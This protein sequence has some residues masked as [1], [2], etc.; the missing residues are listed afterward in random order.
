MVVIV[1]QN[2]HKEKLVRTQP[3]VLLPAVCVPQT[4]LSQLFVTSFPPGLRELEQT[5][6]WVNFIP[7]NEKVD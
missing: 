4:L 2:I 5:K 6:V 1:W 3:H 7:A